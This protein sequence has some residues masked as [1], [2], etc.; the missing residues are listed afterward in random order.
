MRCEFCGCYMLTCQCRF[1]TTEESEVEAMNTCKLCGDKTVTVVN[2]QL[3]ATPVCDY[4]CIAIAKQTLVW[5]G[6]REIE[7]LR[8]GPR[9]TA[10]QKC[11]NSTEA[12]R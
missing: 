6:D 9:A 11:D 8:T 4:C 10:G 5:L 12:K 1:Q 2:I 3:K 7:R